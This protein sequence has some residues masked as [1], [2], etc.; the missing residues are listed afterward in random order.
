M[1]TSPFLGAYRSAKQA[2][3]G[4]SPFELVYRRSPQL[5]ADTCFDTSQTPPEDTQSFMT[6][7]QNR[8]MLAREIVE[9]LQH[10]WRRGVTTTHD[11][12]IGTPLETK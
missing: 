7:L 10:S 4:Y 6:G 8:R 11:P 3:T 12:I 5:P 9:V 1:W 2:S